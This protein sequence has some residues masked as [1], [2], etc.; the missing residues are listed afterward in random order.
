M[1]VSFGRIIPLKSVTNT[2]Q[3]NQ[4]K[5][6]DNSTFEVA[7]VLNSEKSLVYSE[8]EAQKIRNFFKEIL[9]DYNG[10]DGILIKKTGEGELFLI[11]GKDAKHL[12]NKEKIEG[13]I[14][15]VAEDGKRKNKKDSQVVLSS[16]QIVGKSDKSVQQRTKIKLDGFEYYRTQRYFTAKVDG[17]IRTDVQQTESPTMK[18]RCENIFVDYKGLYL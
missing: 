16:S 8:N 15:L 11:S 6:V 7:K 12:Q 18:N 5:R 17:Y 4:R 10:R 3:I 13:Y 2:N 9:S 1:K 14:D